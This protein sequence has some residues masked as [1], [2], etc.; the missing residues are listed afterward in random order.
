MD[1]KNKRGVIEQWVNGGEN[2]RIAA[3]QAQFM[4]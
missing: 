2:K 3:G 1:K 4:D